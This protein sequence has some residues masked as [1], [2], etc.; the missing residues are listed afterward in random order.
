MMQGLM[1]GESRD[2]E[3]VSRPRAT[4]HAGLEVDWG[5]FWKRIAAGNLRIVESVCSETHCNLVLEETLDAEANPLSAADTRILERILV[6][7]SQKAIA[8]DWHSA[9]STIA[10]KAIRSFRSFGLV[11]SSSTVPTALV[12]L[13]HASLGRIPALN[14]EVTTAHDGRISIGIQRPDN[15]LD[16]FFSAAERQVIAFLIE[17]ITQRE[18]AERRNTSPR[19][20]ANQV[21]SA[22]VKLRVS[23]RIAMIGFLLE[24]AARLRDVPLNRRPSGT[25]KRS[26]LP[27]HGGPLPLPGAPAR[28]AR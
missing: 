17:G 6:G 28:P 1:L 27:R 10:T 9:T 18:M 2:D 24:K 15:D 8:L 20:I 19:T 23:G 11:C 21:G 13:V 25:I 12:M 22:Y 14:G 4:T 26:R 16:G 7:E 5:S 3:I